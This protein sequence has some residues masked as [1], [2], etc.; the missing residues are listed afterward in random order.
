[1]ASRS[2]TRWK[3]NEEVGKPC[4]TNSGGAPLVL[5]GRDVDGEDGVVAEGEDP[6]PVPPARRP[7]V[8]ARRRSVKNVEDLVEGGPRR[9]AGPVVE[10]PGEHGVGGF[11]VAVGVARRGVELHADEGVAEQLPEVLEALGGLALSPVNRRPRTV[12]PP[13]SPLLHPADV[14]RRESEVPPVGRDTGKGSDGW[15]RTGATTT[16]STI[17]PSAKPPV[18]HIPTAPTPGPPQ[19]T[20]SS[21]ARARSHPI[22]GLVLPLASTVNSLG[23]AGP[24]ER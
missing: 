4:S 13:R 5:P 14:L 12:Q 3:S 10:V 9:G 22:T 18:K 17:M 15:L 24:G 2:T 6:A 16:L 23:D 7:A 19:R 1:M 11:L 21:A 8:H 20:C